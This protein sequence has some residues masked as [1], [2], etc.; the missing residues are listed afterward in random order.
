MSHCPIALGTA[1]VLLALA[2]CDAP[3][4]PA[5]SMPTTEKMTRPAPRPDAAAPVAVP[6]DDP[7]ASVE[8]SDGPIR[9][10]RFADGTRVSLRG[11][12]VNAKNGLSDGVCGVR[13]GVQRLE[14]IGGGETD[15]Y[16]CVTL[17]DAGA[18]SS[19]RPGRRIGLIYDVSG[20]SSNSAFR[21]A[22]LLLGDDAGWH[23]D[24]DSVGT[25]DDSPAAKSIAAL[26]KAVR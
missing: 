20:P 2:G 7:A 12:K 26:A 17:V 3:A 6:A 15:A 9:P 10:I 1:T 13:I 16:T 25:Y 18:V 23:V 11:W 8:I 14:T 22:I 21:T 24:P 5:R 4:N 19:G